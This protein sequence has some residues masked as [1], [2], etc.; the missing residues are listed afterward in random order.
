MKGAAMRRPSSI[1]WPVARMSDSPASASIAG[2]PAWVSWK[3]RASELMSNSW[4][5]NMK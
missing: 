5:P 3:L 2:L 4:P 1:T